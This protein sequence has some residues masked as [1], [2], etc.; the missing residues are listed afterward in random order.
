MLEQH[1]GCFF[2]FPLILSSCFSGWAGSNHSGPALRGGLRLSDHSAE[3]AGQAHAVLA[4]FSHKHL[5]HQVRNLV[6][7]IL[8]GSKYALVLSQFGS[9]QSLL[10]LQRA[11]QMRGF[12]VGVE[13]V[14]W[15]WFVCSD[16]EA[17]KC[18]VTHLV[19]FWFFSLYFCKGMR[20]AEVALISNRWPVIPLRM[21]T[22]GGLSKILECEYA[23]DLN[24]KLL[25]A[26]LWYR[27]HMWSWAINFS[28][29]AGKGGC[30]H[31][32]PTW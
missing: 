25:Q 24:T 23:E 22:T 1:L 15:C 31:S 13:P 4:P 26:W 32:T 9:S 19:G 5:S 28:C 20:M 18:A 30:L 10:S 3:R 6:G 27:S 16:C 2:F 8:L 29:R 14:V 12:S 17:Q 7:S 11:L 21:W